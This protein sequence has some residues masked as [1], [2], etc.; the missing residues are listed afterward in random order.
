MSR[1]QDQVSREQVPSSKEIPDPPE[2]GSPAEFQIVV[3]SPTEFPLCPRRPKES[4]PGSL[5]QR[6]F[7]APCIPLLRL[8]TQNH[9]QSEDRKEKRRSIDWVGASTLDYRKRNDE[10]RLSQH[11]NPINWETASRPHSAIL[12]SRDVRSDLPSSSIT[13]RNKRRIRLGFT[14]ASTIRIIRITI[15]TFVRGLTA[16]LEASPS[17]APGL[18]RNIAAATLR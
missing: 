6:R 2:K 14:P 18:L 12:S 10:A 7:S 13:Y 5:F 11:Q 16:M 3:R 8:V 15:V 17:P 4:L 9:R 1:S